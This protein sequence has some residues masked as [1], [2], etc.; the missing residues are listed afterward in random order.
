MA[1]PKPLA[2]QLGY[3]MGM[4]LSFKPNVTC[5]PTRNWQNLWFVN[6]FSSSRGQNSVVKNWRL[7]GGS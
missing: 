2:D 4:C 7:V 1:S 5:R 6:V 3:W